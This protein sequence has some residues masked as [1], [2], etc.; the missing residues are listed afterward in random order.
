[1]L[2]S[3]TDGLRG[4]GVLAF[5]RAPKLRPW[6]TEAE[7]RLRAFTE[8]TG[9]GRCCLPTLSPS[10]SASESLSSAIAKSGSAM[11]A[12]KRLLTATGTMV[13]PECD[14]SARETGRGERLPFNAPCRT[15]T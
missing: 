12:L 4:S 1:M 15:V 3:D 5:D 7:R 14:D 9:E 2:D 10:S 11:R 8:G 6:L 13:C